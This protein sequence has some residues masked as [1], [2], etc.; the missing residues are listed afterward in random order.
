MWVTHF[1]NIELGLLHTSTTLNI[2]L[3]SY[4]FGH[5]LMQFRGLTTEAAETSLQARAAKYIFFILLVAGTDPGS[6]I[7]GAHTKKFLK[8]FFL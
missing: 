5:N 8:F 6:F 4:Q 7:G 2:I 3:I 1:P